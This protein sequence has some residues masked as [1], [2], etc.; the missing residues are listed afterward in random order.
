MVLCANLSPSIYH[1]T[2]RPEGVWST[3]KL[4]LSSTHI[5]D[6]QKRIIPTDTKKKGSSSR[7]LFF[8]KVWFSLTLLQSID[9]NR[10]GLDGI[11]HKS[12]NEGT[13][14]R[15]GIGKMF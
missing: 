1:T 15:P 7:S 6:I 14:P 13:D 11:W 2:E 4:S 10:S 12:V 5:F 3:H 9:D 8:Q